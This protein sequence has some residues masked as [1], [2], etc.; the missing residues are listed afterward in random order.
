MNILEN[1]EL[2][3]LI[4]HIKRFSESGIPIYSSKICG[5]EEEDVILKTAKRYTTIFCSFFNIFLN[6]KSLM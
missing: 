4:F 5:K 6:L 3:A 1:P 2:T